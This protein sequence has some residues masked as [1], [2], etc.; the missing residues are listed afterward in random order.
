MIIVANYMGIIG[1]SSKLEYMLKLSDS[2]IKRRLVTTGAVAADNLECSQIGRDILLRHG[3]AVD[4]AIATL[5]CCH[6]INPHSSGIGGSSMITIYDPKENKTIIINA[7]AISPSKGTH[8]VRL[9]IPPVGPLS[10]GIPGEIRGYWE[11]H[12]RYGKLPWK[13]LFAPGIAMLEK[14]VSMTK[15]GVKSTEFIQDKLS[16]RFNGTLKGLFPDLSKIFCYENGEVKQAG[17]I[18]HR[19]AYLQTL[20]K[21]AKYG[22]DYLYSGEGAELLVADLQKQGS[23]LTLDD[24]KNYQPLIMDPLKQQIA[25]GIVLHTTADHSGGILLAFILKTLK[26]YNITHESFNAENEVKTYHLLTEIF[27][28]SSAMYLAGGDPRFTK[29]LDIKL[30]NLYSEEFAQRVRNFIDPAKTQ[31]DELYKK[32]VSDSFGHGRDEGTTHVSVLG[33]DGDAVSITSSINH[34]YGSLIYSNRTGI[35]LNNAM[36]SFFVDGQ[37]NLMEPGKIPSAGS[38]PSILFRNGDINLVIGCSGGDRI[39]STLAMV[40]MELFT[41]NKTLTEAIRAKRY[42]YDMVRPHLMYEADFPQHILQ[43]LRDDYGHKIKQRPNLISAVQAIY[44]DPTTGKII[45]HSD[46]RKQGKAC[47]V[48]QLVLPDI[49]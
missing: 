47:L 41:L 24:L 23:I 2:V 14:G 5:L 37:Y 4:A 39:A 9:K 42:F 45:A 18:I 46:E 21:I 27:K 34:Y 33:P 16:T 29:D 25:D 11:A 36:F 12:Q 20:R 1:I 7:K 35:I 49:L 38:A 44:K 15:D 13:E 10:I 30:K 22:A 19:L 8:Q 17:E 43:Q 28:F 40:L 26:G 31:K 48:K 3:S 6:N 32:I